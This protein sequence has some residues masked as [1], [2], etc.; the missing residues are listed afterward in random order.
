VADHAQA[1]SGFLVRKMCTPAIQC[2]N[3]PS[4]QF[5]QSVQ[6]GIQVVVHEA[7]EHASNEEVEA[8]ER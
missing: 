2:G 7:E 3:P 6:D 8:C 1:V 4:F 5:A